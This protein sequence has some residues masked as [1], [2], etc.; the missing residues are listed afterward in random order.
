[1][2]LRSLAPTR[3]D[4]IDAGFVLALTVVGLYGFQHSYGGSEY[5]IVGVLCAVLGLV[6]AHL[7]NR[8]KSPVLVMLPALFL[9]YVVVGGAIAL[10]SEAA[11]G[12]LPSLD[13]V[14]DALRTTVL[15]WKQLL[16]TVPPVGATGSLMAI[17]AFC[18]SSPVFT[19]MKSGGQRPISCASAALRPISPGAATGVGSCRANICAGS[20]A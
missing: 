18:G 19:W 9:T 1:M 7:G 8:A 5:L 11:A 6:V 4:L 2:N 10:R 15:G 16:T 13:T 3:D 14:R 17:P 20:R 12:F